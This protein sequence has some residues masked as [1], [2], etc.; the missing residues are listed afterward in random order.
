MLL[1][2]DHNTYYNQ[3]G[4]VIKSESPNGLFNKTEYDGAGRTVASYV[5]IDDDETAWSEADDVA[6]D[7]VIEQYETIYDAG[8]RVVAN[9]TGKLQ[10]YRQNLAFWTA[11]HC[12]S[13]KQC[14][15]CASDLPKP[16]PISTPDQGFC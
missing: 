16:K 6:G 12:L 5:S 8:S 11:I 7:T 10:T 2:H 13:P 1:S 4:F 14:L 15:V 9:L 3:R